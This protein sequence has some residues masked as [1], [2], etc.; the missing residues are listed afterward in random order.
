MKE[1]DTVPVIW[2]NVSRDFRWS[3]N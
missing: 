2:D 1:I 3:A